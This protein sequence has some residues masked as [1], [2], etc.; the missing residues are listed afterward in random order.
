MPPKFINKGDLVSVVIAGKVWIMPVDGFY[1]GNRSIIYLL[2]PSGFL[3]SVAAHQ[4]K[5]V[6]G[7]DRNV[8]HLFNRERPPICSQ[9]SHNIKKS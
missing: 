6:H 7:T 3:V 1:D 5:A 8:I 4:V 2:T 9:R